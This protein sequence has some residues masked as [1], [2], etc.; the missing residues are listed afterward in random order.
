LSRRALQTWVLLLAACGDPG[1]HEP[2]LQRQGR[3]GSLRDLVLVERPPAFGGPFFLDR[4]EVTRGDW[5]EF[6]ALPARADDAALPV[7][8]I[9][10]L[11]ARAF[12]AWRFCR[13]LRSKEWDYA[14]TDDGRHAFP[15]G[16]APQASR[17]N[18]HE[19]GIGRP[20]PVGT[21]ESGRRGD[22]QPYDLVGN[23]AEW[24]ESVPEN[25]FQG[26][27]RSAGEGVPWWPDLGLASWKL[28]RVPALCVWLSP[29][30]PVPASL[31]VQALDWRVPREVVG[32]DFRS[33][34]DELHRPRWPR[35]TDSAQGCRLAAD[36]LGLLTALLRHAQPLAADEAR[37]LQ[38]F[39]RRGRHRPVLAGALAAARR[40]CPETPL[41][42]TA[43][44][45][46]LAE[47]GR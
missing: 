20:T 15:W 30:L 32:S 45:M 46:L 23:A 29:G 26:S 7:T 24:T 4:F 14:A 38:A 43:G 19:L 33:S 8:G 39:L 2:G 13:L 27:P 28:A 17:A 10:L 11:Q 22:G 40:L 42:G 34:I 25:W 41:A 3:F 37:Q 12:A 31:L 47:F 6:G 44:A 21:F 18:T 36:P 5:R 1:I 16:E 9:D 35:D